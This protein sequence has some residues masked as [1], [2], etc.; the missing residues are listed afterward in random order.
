MRPTRLSEMRRYF[1]NLAIGFAS[2]GPA[3]QRNDGTQQGEERAGRHRRF[4]SARTCVAVSSRSTTARRGTDGTGGLECSWKRRRSSVRT[5]AGWSRA[6]RRRSRSFS[7]GARLAIHPASSARSFLASWRGGLVVAATLSRSAS[8]RRKSTSA[9]WDAVSV[10]SP[11]GM[12]G[13]S[14]ASSSRLNAPTPTAASQP[15]TAGQSPDLID[16]DEFA[17]QRAS[18]GVQLDRPQPAAAPAVLAQAAE[19]IASAQIRAVATVGVSRAAAGSDPTR[20]STR[21][22]VLRIRARAHLAPC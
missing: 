6:T 17:E 14:S 21:P 22:L 16:A 3:R 4:R 11:G 15:P 9:C 12:G 8:R 1:A 19:P 18:H 2:H 5:V 7:D 20:A 13:S 10:A